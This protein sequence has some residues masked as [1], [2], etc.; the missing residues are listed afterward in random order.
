MKRGETNFSFA[1]RKLPFIFSCSVTAIV[2]GTGINNTKWWKRHRSF[3]RL[4]TQ[5]YWLL[6]VSA[7]KNCVYRGSTRLFSPLFA[8]PMSVLKSRRIYCLKFVSIFLL[9]TGS[10]GLIKEFGGKLERSLWLRFNRKIFLK[11]FQK[12]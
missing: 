5:V 1:Q 11:Y 2:S 8:P 4:R 9:R 3:T 10:K 6:S 7:E 12:M